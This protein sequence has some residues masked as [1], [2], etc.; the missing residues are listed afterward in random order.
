VEDTMMVVDFAG[1][2]EPWRSIDDVVMGGVSS[3]RMVVRD[4]VGT[5]FGE[6]SLANNGGFASARSLPAR[7][8]LSEFDGLTLRV[9]GDGK[10]YGF[11]LRTSSSFDGVSYQIKFTPPAG[12]WA[13]VAIGFSEF[14]PVFRG[15]RVPGAEP[16]DP[17]RVKTLG[18]IISDKQTGPFRLD[19]RWIR[20]W[21]ETDVQGAD[22]DAEVG[23]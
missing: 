22:A 17:S 4:G 13:D 19:I 5:F 20:G 9:R 23:R 1:D 2:A 18:V 14:Q 8:D 12:E 21:T 11:R 15:R 10:T 3:S 6:V 16:L 7:H